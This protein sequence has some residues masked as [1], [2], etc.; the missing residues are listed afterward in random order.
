MIVHFIL[1]GETLESIAKEISLENP[2]YLKEYHNQ[3]CTK[4]DY[5]IDQLRPGKKVLIPDPDK[6]LQ[7]NTN[8]AVAVARPEFNPKLIFKPEKSD[9]KYQVKIVQDNKKD[10]NVISFQVT[11]TWV[12]KDKDEHIFYLSKNNFQDENNSKMIDLAIQCITSLNPVEVRVNAKGEITKINLTK[13]VA[14]NFQQIKERL[15]DLFPDQ[16]AA[17]YIEEFEYVV[18]NE[19][20]FD[21]RMKQDTFIAM[22]FAPIRNVFTNGISTFDHLI[23]DERIPITI[24]QK[25]K[26]VN[27][28][29]EIILL[30]DLKNAHPQ[31]NIDY[32]GNYTLYT[33]TGIVKDIGISYNIS[34]YG[35]KYTTDLS[36]SDML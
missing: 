7:Y 4:E 13:E 17:L 12:R 2:Q 25:V 28:S 24:N 31:N 27:Y 20:L 6:I 23:S 36:V 5:I 1:P 3:H 11:L 22:Y 18:Q 19:K 26:D 34:Q 10:N 35:V 21:E 32:T 29:E 30:Q 15:Y 14:D 33:K 9:M 8:N 16:Y